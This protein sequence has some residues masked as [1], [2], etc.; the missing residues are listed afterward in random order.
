MKRDLRDFINSIENETKRNGCKSL[1]KIM[2]EESGYKAAL[3]GKIVGFGIYHYKYDSGREGDAIVVG[4]SPKSQNITIY[5]M[6]GFSDYEK[7]LKQLGKHKSSKSCLYVNK[8]AD[9]DEKVLRK[10]I[11]HSVQ[12]MKNRYECR[13]A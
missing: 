12:V 4:F 2:E 11:K 6:S 9:I 3:H 10:V 7:E 5:I 13:G 8:L 1:I